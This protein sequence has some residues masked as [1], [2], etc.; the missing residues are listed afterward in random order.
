MSTTTQKIEAF[1]LCQKEARGD[2]GKT[3]LADQIANSGPIGVV[4]DASEFGYTLMG[5]HDLDGIYLWR[6]PL[7]GTNDEV[8]RITGVFPDVG[9]GRVTSEAAWLDVAD[10]NYV[11]IGVHPQKVIDA[12]DAGYQRMTTRKDVVLTIGNSD[13]D[14]ERPDEGYW[15]GT[16][17]G[18]TNTNLT[19]L[20]VEAEPQNKVT[21]KYSLKLT[22]TAANG[23]LLGPAI[24]AVPGQ[25]LVVAPCLRVVGGGPFTLRL[26]DQ[27]NGAFF[28]ETQTYS[29][30]EFAYLY[31]KNAIVPDGCDYWQ[32][33]ISGTDN[34]AIAWL[35]SVPARAKTQAQFMLEDW[36]DE[37]YKLPFIHRVRFASSIPNQQNQYAA[38]NRMFAG[39]LTLDVEYHV[40]AL[41]TEANQRVLDF[42]PIVEMNDDIFYLSTYRDRYLVEPWNDLTDVTTAPRGELT[43]YLMNELCS[44]LLKETGNAFWLQEQATWSGRLGFQATARAEPHYQ[45]VT[46]VV[47][48]KI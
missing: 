17:G 9:G 33:S 31:I 14:M 41:D 36:I 30:A 38:P 2:L 29:G 5:Q 39:D 7:A 26:W 43:A 20:K 1:F 44:L 22:L 3:L 42:E 21:G 10:K 18:S 4:D 27:T 34:G 37:T 11:L 24:R 32:L 12:M 8:R 28:G 35:D 16:Y 15:N 46:E 25:T 40:Q 48:V 45:P 47:V 13:L 23:S 6:Y 19:P